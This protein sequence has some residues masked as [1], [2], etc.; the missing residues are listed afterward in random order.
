MAYRTYKNSA[1]SATMISKTATI[2]KPCQRLRRFRRAWSCFFIIGCTIPRIAEGDRKQGVSIATQQRPGGEAEGAAAQQPAEWRAARHTRSGTCCPLRGVGQN[3]VSFRH[4]THVHWSSL[5]HAGEC[6]VSVYVLLC[7]MVC[8]RTGD[9]N[10]PC[11]YRV[12]LPGMPGPGRARP[13]D[14]APR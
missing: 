4:P 14:W 3:R 10:P 5:H 6:N 2:M 7:P 11:A 9:N 8:R 13:N 1:R 12:G